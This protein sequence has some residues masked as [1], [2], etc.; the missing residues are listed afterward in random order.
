MSD[1]NAPV[2]VMMATHG[3]F[4]PVNNCNYNFEV[5]AFAYIRNHISSVIGIVTKSVMSLVWD[6]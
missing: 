6:L 2:V 1:V 3:N 4:S 5:T